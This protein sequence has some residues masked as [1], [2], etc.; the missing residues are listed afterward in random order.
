MHKVR[1]TK[2]P[3]GDYQSIAVVF[4]ALEI[5]TDIHSLALVSPALSVQLKTAL[6][7]QGI[8]RGTQW[9]FKAMVSPV[10]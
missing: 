9:C 5:H 8:L 2:G 7:S 6:S 3:N 1:P 4:E 10:C